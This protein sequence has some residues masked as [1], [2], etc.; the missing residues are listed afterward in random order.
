VVTQNPD[1]PR[2]G[3]RVIRRGRDVIGVG[4][5]RGLGRGEDALQIVAGEAQEAE[6][7]SVRLQF[8]ELDRQ[9][10][11]VPLGNRGRLVVGNAVRPQLLG[12]QSCAAWTGTRV[13]PSFVAAFQRV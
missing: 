8:L 7:E 9:D 11:E 12:R 4:L 1:V 13:R 6:V 10:L 5:T 2:L 3:D